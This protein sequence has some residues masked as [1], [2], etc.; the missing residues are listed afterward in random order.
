MKC[1]LLSYIELVYH[2]VELCTVELLVYCHSTIIY[3]QYC[4]PFGFTEAEYK[5]SSV[6]KLTCENGK[7]N[8]FYFIVHHT[9]VDVENLKFGK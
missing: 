9:R 3:I 7:C 1:Q 5:S 2:F 4:L 6:Y 8:T